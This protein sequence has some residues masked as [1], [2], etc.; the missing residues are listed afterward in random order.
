VE[1][2]IGWMPVE[3]TE[4]GL[5][6]RLFGFLP[7]SFEV[8]HWH[9]DTFDLPPVSVHLARS[10]ICANQAFVHEGRV[11]GLQFHL[12]ATPASVRAIVGHC[13]DEL[14]PAPHIQTAERMLAAKQEDYDR[15]NG[16]L[17]GILDQL[18]GGLE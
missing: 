3:L 13:A 8:F 7:P 1:K 16:A 18:P 11:L 9:G 6:S 12:E 14:V 5:A 17:F 2:E 15:I 4:P 10:A